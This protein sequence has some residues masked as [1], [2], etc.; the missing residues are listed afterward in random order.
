MFASQGSHQMY[1]SR[2]TAVCSHTTVT[3]SRSTGKNLCVVPGVAYRQKKQNG[4][5]HVTQRTSRWHGKMLD[6]SI[7]ST[8]FR[9]RVAFTAQR[10]LCR[11]PKGADNARHLMYMHI[12]PSVYLEQLLPQKVD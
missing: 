12:A 6:L 4:H 2:C 10:K 7:N 5:I 3:L 11:V 1:I 8:L 9:I